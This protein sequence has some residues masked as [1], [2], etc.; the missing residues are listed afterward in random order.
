MARAIWSGTIAFGLVSI[1]VRMES[2]V[3]EHTLH[4]NYVHE[5]DGGRIGYQKVCKKEERPVP[6]DEVV[7]A[8]EVKKG[9]WVYLADED[10]E[11][12]ALEE[13][14][15]TIDIHAFVPRDEIDPIFFERTYYLAPQEGGEKVYALLGRA[16]E[17]AGLVAVAT[18][19]MRERE[20]LACLRVRDR[21][22]TLERMHFAD[23]IRP[24]KDL[25][26]KGVRL[27]KD[28][29]RMAAQLVDRYAG[30]FRPDR[31]KD[32]YRDALLK[33]IKAKER[34]E[35]VSVA[36]PEEPEEPVDLDDRPSGERRVGQGAARSQEA[37]AGHEAQGGRLGLSDRCTRPGRARDALLGAQVSRSREYQRSAVTTAHSSRVSMVSGSSRSARS[38]P[39][40]R[41][42]SSSS[43]SVEM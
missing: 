30:K 2:A 32:T 20:H 27:G 4:F 8:F 1:P 22:L 3:E 37:L 12:A 38:R 43:R 41:A 29:L 24:A 7:K 42:P 18:F 19:V 9:K 5:P 34:G 16:M 14:R 40:V 31:F 11:S 21:V 13:A 35:T 39:S 26:P 17:E 36:E 23:E 10:F 15:K 33:A 25:A 28:E 6:D